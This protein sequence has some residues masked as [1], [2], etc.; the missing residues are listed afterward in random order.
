MS[1]TFTIQREFSCFHMLLHNKDVA[2]NYEQDKLAIYNISSPILN[3][4]FDL[5]GR[6]EGKVL[7]TFTSFHV[8]TNSLKRFTSSLDPR[9]N[10]VR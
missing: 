1:D 5:L 8:Q 10:A 3:I 2:T 7:I 6:V 4:A 9:H